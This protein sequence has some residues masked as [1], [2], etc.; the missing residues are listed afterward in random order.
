MDESNELT[1]LASPN[2]YET[3]SVIKKAEMRINKKF[4]PVKSNKRTCLD[5]NITLSRTLSK[6]QMILT[7]KIAVVKYLEEK[8][9]VL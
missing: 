2:S 7:I 9:M 1:F 5:K 8:K 6:K 3:S 4:S